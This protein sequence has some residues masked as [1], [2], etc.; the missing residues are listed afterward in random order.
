MFVTCYRIH[1][2]NGQFLDVAECSEEEPTLQLISRFE[3]ALPDGMFMLGA[4]D[5][6]QKFIPANN[7]LYI[8]VDP[9]GEE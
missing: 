3:N 5:M 1:F 4:E 9:D 8:S 6:P 7:V 2:I